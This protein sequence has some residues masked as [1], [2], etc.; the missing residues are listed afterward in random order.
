MTGR[1]LP[2][3]PLSPTGAVVSTPIPGSRERARP[4]AALR[5]RCRLLGRDVGFRVP[6]IRQRQPLAHEPLA[7]VDVALLALGNEA[8]VPINIPLSAGDGTT[9]DQVLQRQG[10]PLPAAPCPAGSVDTGLAALGR[11]NSVQPYPLAGKV[12]SVATRAAPAPM[13]TGSARRRAKRL[14]VP[15]TAAASR[16]LSRARTTPAPRWRPG[17]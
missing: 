15:A 3:G 17:R 10:R 8:A 13:R 11:I 1:F 5:C 6:P 7:D 9:P 2:R 14:T 16:D 4:H 12:E